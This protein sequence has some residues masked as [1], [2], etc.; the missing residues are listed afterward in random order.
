[1]APR[2]VGERVLDGVRANRL[3]IFTHADQRAPVEERHREMMAAYDAI[4]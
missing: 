2:E 3:Y 4:D 1:M